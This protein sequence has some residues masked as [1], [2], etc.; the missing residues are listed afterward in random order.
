MTTMKRLVK[1]FL[2]AL[3]AISTVAPA[4]AQDRP[5]VGIERKSGLPTCGEVFDKREVPGAPAGV[6][7]AAGYGREVMAA[8]DC[9]KK[10]NLAMACE[11][12]R[13]LLAIAGTLGSPWNESRGDIENLMRQNKC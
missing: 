7:A 12:W 8:S 4:Q 11:H 3:L 1:S 2:P 13:R 5:L 6:M 9:I 10:N